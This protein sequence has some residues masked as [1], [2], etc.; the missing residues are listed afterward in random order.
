MNKAE[1]SRG[2]AS[3]L[4]SLKVNCTELFTPDDKTSSRI[5]VGGAYDV[6]KNE[7]QIYLGAGLFG[8]DSTFYG[9]KLNIKEASSVSK[10]AYTSL[11]AHSFLHELVH[12]CE[13][14]LP[15]I[16]ISK[17]TVNQAAHQ[18]VSAWAAHTSQT[19]GVPAPF[20]IAQAQGGTA[21]PDLQASILESF[22]IG[23]MAYSHCSR[24]KLALLYMTS[25]DTK[26]M[27][28]RPSFVPQIKKSILDTQLLMRT[29]LGDFSSKLDTTLLEAQKQAYKWEEAIY[30]EYKDAIDSGGLVFR[31]K[32]EIATTD[33]VLAALNRRKSKLY[34]NPSMQVEDFVYSSEVPEDLFYTIEGNANLLTMR[35]EGDAFEQI[36]LI[37]DHMTLTPSRSIPVNIGD[38]F[39]GMTIEDGVVQYIY[40]D[41]G[42]AFTKVTIEEAWWLLTL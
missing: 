22:E 3:R 5:S 6:K 19:T 29:A 12:L 16:A 18:L 32:S 21:P 23:H 37:L 41:Y 2:I 8:V 40:S 14:C 7:I 20:L 36:A 4:K 27:F 13:Q 25:I 35:Y 1:V 15:E 28:I 42:E 30:Q 34:H 33:D 9:G 17:D 24:F 39:L 11:A 26:A 10:E 31:P 38:P